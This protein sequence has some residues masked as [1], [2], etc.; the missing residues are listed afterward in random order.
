MVHFVCVLCVNDVLILGSMLALAIALVLILGSMLALAIIV[1]LV[2][3][4]GSKSL[5]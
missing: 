3:I 5:I 1:A 4:M 2:L